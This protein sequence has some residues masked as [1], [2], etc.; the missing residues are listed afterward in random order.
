[1]LIF[2]GIIHFFGDVFVMQTQ[3]RFE[4]HFCWG[5]TNL[6]WNHNHVETLKI[7]LKPLKPFLF[8]GD[9]I[10][11]TTC[12]SRTESRRGFRRSESEPW[13]D[14]CSFRRKNASLER[15]KVHWAMKEGPNWLFRIFLGMKS[16]PVMWGVFHKPFVTSIPLNDQYYGKYPSVF[17]A[18]VSWPL[19]SL[20]TLR[21]YRPCVIQAHPLFQWWLGMAE[22]CLKR[23][24]P[25][26]API[27]LLMGE[28][29]H[30]LIGSL[31]HYLPGCYTSKVVAWA[32]TVGR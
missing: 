9:S 31:S 32:S 1:M 3:I 17:F 8:S 22:L 20:A 14:R 21:T 13:T 15:E 10:H 27:L 19:K 28:I 25:S 12:F 18:Q 23:K 5:S 2:R 30:Q 11:Q 24:N 6:S 4:N 7:N 26:K 29:L 16:Y